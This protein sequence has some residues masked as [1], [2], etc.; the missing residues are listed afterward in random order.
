MD[1]FV[2]MIAFAKVVLFKR[3]SHTEKFSTCLV[4]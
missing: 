2:E 3:E 4:T 1:Y